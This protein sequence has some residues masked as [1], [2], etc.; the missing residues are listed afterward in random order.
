MSDGRKAWNT[1]SRTKTLP[2]E[3]TAGDQAGTKGRERSE[4]NRMNVIAVIRLYY[5]EGVFYRS[6]LL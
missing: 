3:I 1:N 2:P 6:N 4:K 5:G